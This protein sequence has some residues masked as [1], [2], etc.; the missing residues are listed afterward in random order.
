MSQLAWSAPR[1]FDNLQTAVSGG[2]CEWLQPVKFAWQW[3]QWSTFLCSGWL[4][5][6]R[7]PPCLRRCLSQVTQILCHT[8]GTA[9]SSRQLQEASCHNLY[10]FHEASANMQRIASVLGSQE[11]RPWEGALLMLC[12]IAFATKATSSYRRV[13]SMQF[14]QDNTTGETRITF[15]LVVVVLWCL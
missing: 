15:L 9:L 6:L 10:W 1:C 7:F 14:W 13:T 4:Y 5:E 2:G 3:E 8:L 11:K 12:L